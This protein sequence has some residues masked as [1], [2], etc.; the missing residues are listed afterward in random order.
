MLTKLKRLRCKNEVSLFLLMLTLTMPIFNA[1]NSIAMAIAIFV[2]ILE[3]KNLNFK[4]LPKS[5][6]LI[7]LFFIAAIVFSSLAINDMKSVRSALKFLYWMLPFFVVFYNVQLC[8]NDK[9][10]LY[11]LVIALFVSAFAVIYQYH[12]DNKIRPGGLYFHPNYFAGMMD[13][14]LP[15]AV[16]FIL[17]NIH[18][19][20]N[21]FD[22]K[23]LL[24]SVIT[25]VYALFLSGSRGGIIGVIAGLLL[26]LICYHLRK[27]KLSHFILVLSS[28]TVLFVGTMFVAYEFM[29]DLLQRRYDNERLL[30]IE[31][32]Y[33]M[34]ND[35]KLFG[36]GLDNWEEEY[37]NKYRLPEAKEYL[38]QPH[39]IL[40][41]L[42]ST[43]G[44]V[45]GT[46]FFIFIG[47]IFI[48]LVKKLH[49]AQ[50]KEIIIII[51]AMLWAFFAVNIHGMVDVGLNSKSIMR[52]FT[53][54]FGLTLAYAA[55]EK[56]K[57]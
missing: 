35:N 20:K 53:A 8:K 57:K 11:S 32:S 37:D 26:C 16:M 30:L 34:W 48:L 9:I 54:C 7:A 44:V 46:G 23:I 38:H 12:F 45:G 36:I 28:I 4:I 3:Y 15:F 13:I 1:A 22:G 29:P 24:V 27:L 47:G 19:S 50:R 42:F 18:E 56:V 14:L 55:L 17:K 49:D 51:L 41:F 39:N 21:I 43:T 10:I 52:L 25:G 5:I 6:I 33:N 40:A 31:S 2:L